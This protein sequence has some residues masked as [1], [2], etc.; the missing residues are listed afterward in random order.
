[1]AAKQILFDQAARDSILRGVNVLADA[2]KVTLGPKGRNVVI[3]KSFGSPT[4]TKDGVTVAK[5]IELENKFENMGAQMVKEVASKT[6]DV[7]GDGT[8]TATVLAQAIYREGS[9]LVA[10][11]H[12]PME[13]KRG[14]DKAVEVVVGEL[15][16]LSKATASQKEIAQVGI[17]SAN[18]DETIGNIIAEAMEKV[19]KEGVITVEEAKGLETTLEVVEGMQ[20]DRGYLSPYFVTD[21]EAMEAELEDVYVL[22][23]EK[24]ISNMKDL[25]PLL[26]QVA[27][28]GKPLLIIAED[29]EGEALATLVVNK[30]RGTL[31]GCAVKAPGFGDRRKAM[32]EDIAILTGGKMIAEELGLKLEQVTLKDLGK[33][34][35]IVVDKDNT[36]IVDGAGKKDDIAAR[37]KTIRA[38]IEETTSDYDREKLQERLAKLVGGVAVINVGAATETEMKEK[39]ARVEDALHATRAAVEEGIVP[40]GGVAY[41]RSLKALEKLQVDE[42]EKFGVQLVR[43]AL[44]EPLRQIAENGGLEG[45]IVVNRVRESKETNFGYNASTGDYEDLVKAGVIDPTKVSRTALQNASSVASL[46]LTTMA[47]IADK[48]KE[49]EEGAAGG[50]MPGGMGGMGM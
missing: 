24:K 1:M 25:L 23:H 32:L 22:I 9:K 8:T 35:R 20:F 14:I 34:K 41:L 30:L 43:R 27:R 2:V 48:P 31:H 18:G 7:A 42:G 4:I 21:P 50:G 3:E 44:E 39:K 17:I 15:K 19:G 12:N 5:E 40:G 28:G 45:S 10:A 49:K 37:V 29:V 47:L 13:I 26:E 46:M 16:K 36:T 11:G 38:Q 6:S 33:A